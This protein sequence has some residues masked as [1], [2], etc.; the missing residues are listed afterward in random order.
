[1]ARL[2]GRMFLIVLGYGLACLAASGFFHLL[3]LG[4]MRLTA[5]EE[6]LVAITSFL[7]VPG[8]AVAAGY[9]MA[10]P[11]AVLAALAEIATIRDWVWHALGGALAA[12]A[13]AL[14]AYGPLHLQQDTGLLATVIACGLVAGIVY[15]LV[16]GR[17]SGGWGETLNGP[18]SSGS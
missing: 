3:V 18:A 15:W 6:Q 12:V 9:H 16:A 11:A 14:A 10:V 2:I 8:V 1:M 13:G 5:D 17:G 4:G 7:T